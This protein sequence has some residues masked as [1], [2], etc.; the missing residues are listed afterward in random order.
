M[1]KALALVALLFAFGSP[2][3]R[4]PHNFK[5]DGHSA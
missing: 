5:V 4:M 2:P 3:I 1:R